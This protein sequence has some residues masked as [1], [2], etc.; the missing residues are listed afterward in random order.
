MGTYSSR[1]MDYSFLDLSVMRMSFWRLAFFDYDCSR[2]FTPAFLNVMGCESAFLKRPMI[3]APASR[4]FA[5][6]PY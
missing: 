1:I 4:P 6:V 2:V 5:S 3:V